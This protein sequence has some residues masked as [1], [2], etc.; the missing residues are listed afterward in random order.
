[1]RLVLEPAFTGFE[2][3]ATKE[4]L[5]S[6][7]HGIGFDEAI[8]ALSQP[9]IE[10]RSDRK[11]ESR[12]LAICQSFGRIITIIYTAR[13]ENCR[14]ISARPARDYE[15]HQYRDHFLGRGT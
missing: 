15:E 6:K 4:L 3:D 10:Q 1:M 11:E 14:I 13:G 8:V 7:R 12:T 5:N 2:W 9:H